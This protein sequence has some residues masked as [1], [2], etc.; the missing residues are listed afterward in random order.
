MNAMEIVW[1]INLRDKPQFAEWN[2]THAIEI[3][4]PCLM[5][6]SIMAVTLC[7]MIFAKYKNDIL[8]LYILYIYIEH[9]F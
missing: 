5:I 1:N 4:H 6:K 9:L 8:L 7:A 3:V 2:A